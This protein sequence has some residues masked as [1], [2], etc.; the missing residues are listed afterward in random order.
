MPI[1]LNNI[2]NSLLRTPKKQAQSQ[3]PFKAHHFPSEKID[4]VILSSKNKEKQDHN[5]LKTRQ[6]LSFLSIFAPFSKQKE[7]LKKGAQLPFE[8]EKE[9]IQI[10]QK[11]ISK[12]PIVNIESYG[13]L[14]TIKVDIQ[15]KKANLRCFERHFD[16]KETSDFPKEYLDFNGKMHCLYISHLTGEGSG[17]GTE[18]VKKAVE[19]SKE[20]GLKGK[21]ALEATTIDRSKGTPIPF[22]YK[23]GFKCPTKKI[24]KEIEEG[25]KNLEKT[26]HYTGPKSAF[27]YLPIKNVERFLN[28]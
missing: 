3:I 18:A 9:S 15:G 23:L 7:K 27:L 21:I 14:Y 5:A 28:M 17:S 8:A 26:G 25:M 12:K 10:S 24:Q 2:N 1:A 6:R 4:E 11:T 16:R 20:L 22:Y 19:L 13:E